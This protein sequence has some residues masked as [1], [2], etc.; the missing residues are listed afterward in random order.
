M[1]ISLHHDADLYT[2]LQIAD[3]GCG[4]EIKRNGAR[5]R[6]YGMGLNSIQERAELTGGVF[7]LLNN[8][9]VGTVIE[10]K[11]GPV[12]GIV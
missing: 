1:K 4:I 8:H 2:T 7:N 11:W 9:P 5:Y 3:N 12:N 6:N 10:V